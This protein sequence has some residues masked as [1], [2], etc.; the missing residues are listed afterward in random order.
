MVSR[1]WIS[2]S[3]LSSSATS[4]D[5]SAD[6]IYTPDMCNTS[7]ALPVVALG[8]IEPFNYMTLRSASI[9]F[10]YNIHAERLSA[11]GL[12]RYEHRRC[13]VTLQ[14]HRIDHGKGL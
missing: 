14:L 5:W 7:E 8:F 11:F 2:S 6:N 10:I 1:W 9:V 12:Q 13:S 4:L 3:S